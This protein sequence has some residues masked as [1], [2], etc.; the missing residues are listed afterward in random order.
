MNIEPEAVKTQLRLFIQEHF[1][2]PPNDQ[3]FSDDVHLFDYGYVDS[4]GAVELTT[5]VKNQFGVEIKDN[6]LI[7]Y[8]LNTIDEIATF[9]VKRTKGEI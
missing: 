4:F 9:I 6:D 3:D 2:V 8:P 5:F 1:K 7:V